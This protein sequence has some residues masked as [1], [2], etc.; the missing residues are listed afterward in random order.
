MFSL[1]A[2]EERTGKANYRHLPTT[3]VR[4]PRL[5]AILAAHS[6]GSKPRPNPAKKSFQRPCT[7]QRC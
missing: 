5:T 3:K 2:A 1:E 7:D 6:S 4:F